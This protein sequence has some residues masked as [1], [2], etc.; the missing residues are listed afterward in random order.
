MNKIN[1][2]KSINLEDLFLSV[3]RYFILIFLV[4]S[5]VASLT[6]LISG[7]FDL[8]A[9][10]E[11]YKNEKIDSKQLIVDFKKSLEN[12]KIIKPAIKANTQK[13]NK[14]LEEEI[15]KQLNLITN[16]YRRY[17][18]QLPSDFLNDHLEQSLLKNA[19]TY[20][21]YYGVGDA[22]FLQ[23][24]KGQTLILEIILLNPELNEVLTKK[25]NPNSNL[26]EDLKYQPIHAFFYKVIDYFPEYHKKII[27]N[28]KIFETYQNDE[29]NFRKEGAAIKIYTALGLFG[30]FLIISLILVLVKIERNLRVVKIKNNE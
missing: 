16:Y 28:K 3:L 22:G 6:L 7:F 11:L 29:V 21:I 5:S 27:E 9:K 25:F 23:Y 12:E 17:N 13:N 20:G 10:V 19:K 1:S 14:E 18:Y 4:I 24:A 26:D 15:L 2:L 8:N 30:A